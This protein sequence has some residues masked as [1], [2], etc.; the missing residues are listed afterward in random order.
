MI[1]SL[2]G[3]IFFPARKWYSFQNITKTLYKIAIQN[4]LFMNFPQCL[5]AGQ[6]LYCFHQQHIKLACK[7]ILACVLF[8]VSLSWD[9]LHTEICSLRD[10]WKSFI[11][12]AVILGHLEAKKIRS[13][14]F[15]QPVHSRTGELGFQSVVCNQIQQNSICWDRQTGHW[16]ELER[17][18]NKKERKKWW[19]LNFLQQG[20]KGT[21]TYFVKHAN[22]AILKHSKKYYVVKKSDSNMLGRI[23]QRCRY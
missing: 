23:L 15:G 6:N 8:K 19:H 5:E 3:R 1:I 18:V 4:E 11:V 22:F 9:K 12:L 17:K 2:N 20:T 16:R 14:I 10:Q 7:S 13:N 21:R